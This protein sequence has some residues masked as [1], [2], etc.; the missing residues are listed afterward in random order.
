MQQLKTG[1][2]DNT[3][4]KRVP[5]DG[6]VRQAETTV[7]PAGQGQVE[8]VVKVAPDP[9]VGA[10][11]VHER[12]EVK[13]AGG[14]VRHEEHVL[15]ARGKTVEC[16]VWR[17]PTIMVKLEQASAERMHAALHLH[18]HLCACTA[19]CARRADDLLRSDS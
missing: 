10:Q 14:P 9:G 6:A 2:T 11:V 7:S 1:V 18:Q 17:S 16:S 15:R 4:S 8:H 13:R 12:D 19:Q 3:M 5:R